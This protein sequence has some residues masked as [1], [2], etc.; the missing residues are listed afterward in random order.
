MNSSHSVHTTTAWAKNKNY[1]GLSD[2]IIIYHFQQQCRGQDNTI[3]DCWSSP[4]CW[5]WDAPAPWSPGHGSPWDHGWRD[6]LLH[7]EDVWWYKWPEI[8]EYHLNMLVKVL[9]SHAMIKLWT[10]QCKEAKTFGHCSCIFLESKSQNA[11]FLVCDRVEETFNNS[12]SKSQ[13]KFGWN[14]FIRLEDCQTFGSCW[15]WQPGSNIPQPLEGWDTRWCK[16]SW[17]YPSEN[18]IHRTRLQPWE[19]WVQSW[20]RDQ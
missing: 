9:A 7:Q 19:T 15:S 11:N 5:D 20:C 18:M 13:S 14:S 10:R 16:P 6:E 2:F 1:P 3:Q 17:E 12:L 4:D 8:L